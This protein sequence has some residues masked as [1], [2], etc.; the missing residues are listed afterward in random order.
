MHRVKRAIIMA[1]GK[2]ERMRPITEDTPKPLVRVNGTRMIDSVINGLHQNGI[3]EIYVVV[4]YLK[5]QFQSL[6]EQYPDITLIENPDFDSWNNVAS[7]YAARA[8][9]SDCMIMDG[10]QIIYQ[11]EILDPC[12]DR[13]CYNAI[14]TDSPTNEWLLQVENGIV[15][16]CSRTGGSHGWQLYS[17]S[18]WTAEDGAKLRRHLEQEY[19]KG[20]RTIFWDDLPLFLYR[21]EYEIGIHKMKKEAVVE[22]DTFD[23]L[24]SIDPSY[25]STN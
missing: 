22:I 16:D 8:Y 17:I 19:H 24:K 15:K 3:F 13:S 5:E 23:E 12:F 7:L 6:A 18:R 11:P 2:G 14:R 9:L 4:G 25:R 21:D 1:A 20:N 10:D